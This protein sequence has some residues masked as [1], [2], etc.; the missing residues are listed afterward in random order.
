MATSPKCCQL[1][2][3]SH[4][5]TPKGRFETIAGLNTYIVGPENATRGIIDLFD[6]FGI[7]PSQTIQGADRLAAHA[8]AVVLVP[9]FF[10]GQGLDPSL[11]PMDTDEKRAK[12]MEFMAAVGDIPRS[13]AKLVEVRRAAAERFPAAGDRW[14]AFGLCWGGKVAV[15]ASGEGNDGEGR[16]FKASG[17]THPGLMD[18]KDAKAVTCPHLVLVTP[19]EPAD[20][21]AQYK[22][23][24]SQPGKEGSSV[25]KFET[26]FHGWMGARAKLTDEENVKEY[27]RG[28]AMVGKFF[29]EQL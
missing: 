27:E 9:D 2:P 29:S 6:I 15:L 5:Y 13:V 22:E 25:V 12:V 19:D 21:V 17:Q 26:M 28:Y 23:A 18:E 14:G 16:R 11:V 24:L 20:V 7:K 4:E 1:P 8:D 10:H 3:V